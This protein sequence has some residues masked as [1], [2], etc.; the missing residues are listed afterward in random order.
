MSPDS[1]SSKRDPERR[2][3][4]WVQAARYT[5]LALVFPAALV[6]GWLIGA[7]LDRWLH[8]TFL[9]LVGILLGIVAGFTELIRTVMRD[10]K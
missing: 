2:E 3:N 7:A 8:T 1:D 10:T 4:F 5:Q 6:V 9:Y